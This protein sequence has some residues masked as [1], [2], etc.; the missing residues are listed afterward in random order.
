MEILQKRMSN[1][2]PG[3]KKFLAYHGLFSNY[4]TNDKEDILTADK[5]IIAY[6]FMTSVDKKSSEDLKAATMTN[7]DELIKT[8]LD[9][10]YSKGKYL[11]FPTI[12]NQYNKVFSKNLLSSGIIS[13]Q[14]NQYEKN[15]NFSPYNKFLF[16]NNDLGLHALSIIRKLMESEEMIKFKRSEKL[17]YKWIIENQIY[18]Q[19]L[20]PLNN[21]LFNSIIDFR[22]Q[23]KKNIFT[24]E[25][26]T[27]K[28]DEFIRGNDIK[29][30]FG[31]PPIKYNKTILDK[32]R[33]HVY[34]DYITKS[35]NISDVIAMYI[36]SRFLQ[37]DKE[38]GQT[39]KLFKLRNNLK[40]NL[41]VIRNYKTKSSDIYNGRTYFIFDKNYSG[42]C[43]YE[44]VKID[45]AKYDIILKEVDYYKS[46]L[47]KKLNKH[48]L[49]KNI[50]KKY[51]QNYSGVSQKKI[52]DGKI[53]LY[54]K[55]VEGTLAIYMGKHQKFYVKK[56]A[57]KS[58][59]HSNRNWKVLYSY[60]TSRNGKCLNAKMIDPYEIYYDQYSAFFLEG[61]KK[62][63]SLESYLNTKFANKIVDIR[64]INNRVKDFHLEWL[65]N[66][67][68]DRIWTD[69]EVHKYFKLNKKEI[70]LLK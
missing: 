67:P 15:Y 12:L 60:F 54:K 48:P 40:S 55:Q 68:L 17:R 9:K 7:A 69:E 43:D 16:I 33:N 27:P 53:K 63:K 8:C 31:C 29:C 22:N 44:G 66:V 51:D 28:F 26:L 36:P 56:D 45:L 57:I 25:F 58:R 1:L 34:V 23:F 18:T 11:N 52:R 61:K 59:L 62:A 32:G 14:I 30:I 47:I 65:P 5:A 10:N 3:L 13:G 24:G 21:F 42:K 70:D 2:D 50:V 35:M 20:S 19:D 38:R 4:Y 37:I 39:A 46:N 6:Y 41:K 64:K 49:L